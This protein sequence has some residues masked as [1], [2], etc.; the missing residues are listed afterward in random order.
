MVASFRSLVQRPGLLLLPGP[1]ATIK[2]AS[3]PIRLQSHSCLF[4]RIGIANLRL[5][6]RVQVGRV[7]GVRVCAAHI[8]NNR[9]YA[10]FQPRFFSG[11]V[12]AAPCVP[13]LATHRVCLLAG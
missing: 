12:R 13:C 6:L 5:H 7:A 1:I 2:K 11:A 3:L 10:A 4:D 9:R 8:R